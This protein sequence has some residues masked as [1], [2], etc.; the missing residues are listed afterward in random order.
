MSQKIKT[1][2]RWMSKK[3]KVTL[4]NSL[5]CLFN[6]LIKI[7]IFFYLIYLIFYLYSSISSSCSGLN[8]QPIEIDCAISDAVRDLNNVL[9]RQLGIELWHGIVFIRFS[10]ST[11]N[12]LQLFI[13]IDKFLKMQ[14]FLC[15]NS[16]LKHPRIPN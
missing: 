1:F 12:I 4:S 11:V 10:L 6:A 15:L 3:H 9:L 2:S 16:F 5:Y 7:S 13:I 14:L 8:N